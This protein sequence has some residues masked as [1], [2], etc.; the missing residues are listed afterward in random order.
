MQDV[1]QDKAKRAHRKAQ[2]ECGGRD[3]RPKI[4]CD[5]GDS[6]SNII[7]LF[8]V[9]ISLIFTSTLETHIN[10]IQSKLNPEGIII[11]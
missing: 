10:N 5:T 3:V 8:K 4:Q 1:L 9:R 2:W 6:V 7:R 11:F